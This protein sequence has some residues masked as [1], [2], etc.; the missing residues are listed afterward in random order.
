MPN[1]FLS[2]TALILFITLCGLGIA[3]V[4]YLFI[5]VKIVK[6]RIITTLIIA[7]N[8]ATDWSFVGTSLFSLF[9][10]VNLPK[11]KGILSILKDL[12]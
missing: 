6:E 10:L 7:E 9:K 11:K 12:L 8:N 1:E 4:I 2:N 3:F 5:F